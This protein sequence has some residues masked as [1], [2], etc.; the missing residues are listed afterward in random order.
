MREQTPHKGYAFRKII[1]VFMKPDRF[2]M[3]SDKCFTKPNN[4]FV[5]KQVWFF[6]KSIKFFMNKYRN[7]SFGE[8][9]FYRTELIYSGCKTVW[10]SKLLLSI[11]VVKKVRETWKKSSFLKITYFRFYGK[12]N[13]YVVAVKGGSSK[14]S[15]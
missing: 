15:R 4:V 9:C 14:C 6:C 8:H 12:F 13:R 7:I 2:V 10:R 5:R 3:K 11:T 1:V